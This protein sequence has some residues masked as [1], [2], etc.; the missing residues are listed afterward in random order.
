MLE[1]DVA[2]KDSLTQ[3]P[4]Q[5][6]QPRRS[7]FRHENAYLVHRTSRW[8]CEVMSM[9]KNKFLA[10]RESGGSAFTASSAFRDADAPNITAS[11][12]HVTIEPKRVSPPKA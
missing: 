7:L 6:Q 12:A 11:A 5:H 2:A 3:L 10:R 4:S 1:Q 9:A 8:D